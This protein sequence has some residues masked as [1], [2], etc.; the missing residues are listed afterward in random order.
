MVLPANRSLNAVEELRAKMDRGQP[1]LGMGVSLADPLVSEMAV[2]A[3]FDFVWIENEH[4][5]MTTKDVLHHILTLRGTGVAPMVRVPAADVTLIKPYVDLCPAV[6]V[7]PFVR[8]A[9]EARVAVSACRYPPQ[10]VRGF[11]PI[12]NMGHGELE[13]DEY[14]SKADRQVMVFVQVEHVDAVADLDALVSTP[15]LDGICLGRNDLSGSV[16]KLGQYDDTEVVEMINTLLEKCQGTGLYLGASLGRDYEAVQ[17]WAERG[18][19]WFSLG[20]DTSFVADSARALRADYDGL[21]A[22]KKRL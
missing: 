13:F 11:G 22:I 12:R 3:G 8:S 15:G 10:G 21:E 7:V 17:R 20:D 18:M 5:Y 16:G 9:A 4:A 2:D 6:I 1:V 19:V 14:L